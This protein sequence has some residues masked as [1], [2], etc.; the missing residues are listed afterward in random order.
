MSKAEKAAW[1]LDAETLSLIWQGQHIPLLPKEYRL[2]AYLLAHP[3]RTFSR[4]ELLDAVWPNDAPTDRTVD[5]HVYRLRRKLTPAAPWFTIQTVRSRGYRLV[6]ANAKTQAANPSSIAGILP[7]EG[8]PPTAETL[9]TDGAVPVSLLHDP[10][11]RNGVRS[12]F[13]TYYL[14]GQGEAVRMLASESQWFGVEHDAELALRVHFIQADFA[15]ILNDTANTF[16]AKSF[17][18]LVIYD[19]IQFDAAKSLRLY[20]RA[21]RSGVLNPEFEQEIRVFNLTRV[22]LATG[23]LSLAQEHYTKV[24]AKVKAEN[25]VGYLP[26]LLLIGATV[27][28]Y[29]DQFDTAREKLCEVDEFLRNS[30]WQRELAARQIVEGLFAAKTGDPVAAEQG[31]E[32]GLQTDKKSGFIVN[33]VWHLHTILNFLR[34]SVSLPDLQTKYEAMWLD[35]QREYQLRNLEVP[36]YQLLDKNF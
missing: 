31:F 13:L 15:W 7:T 36:L 11:F 1:A 12:L 17:W 27:Y 14:H 32:A 3:N 29:A 21:L 24:E 33:I 19:M 6:L 18:L 26:A 10:D 16:A 25:N 30:P 8:V 28:L 9:P 2:L 5:D 35:V 20:E 23:Q 22:Y 34:N 4:E